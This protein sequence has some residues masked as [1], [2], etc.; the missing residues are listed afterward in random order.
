MP[1]LGEISVESSMW[2]ERETASPLPPVLYVAFGR[3]PSL[4]ITSHMPFAPSG[5]SS[6]SD[7]YSLARCSDHVLS[8]DALRLRARR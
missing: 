3:T 4:E 6:V 5:T 8:L 1:A 2:Y 7:L